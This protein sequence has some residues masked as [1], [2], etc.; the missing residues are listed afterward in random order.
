MILENSDFQKDFDKCVT[1]YKGF[2]KQS[3]SNPSETRQVL[4]MSSVGCC[5]IGRKKGEDRYYTKDKYIK[6]SREQKG[7]IKKIHDK[8]SSNAGGGGSSEP[9][10][11]I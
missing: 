8:C 1:L 9:K 4:D 10:Y 2:L 6:L 3:N 11:R 5:G 7:K